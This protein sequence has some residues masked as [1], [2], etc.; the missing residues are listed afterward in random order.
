MG[1]YNFDEGWANNEWFFIYIEKGK[2]KCLGVEMR[3]CIQYPGS[4]TRSC[5]SFPTH[6]PSLPGKF[7]SNSMRK[8]PSSLPLLVLFLLI[9]KS[10]KLSKG[11]AKPAHMVPNRIV[12]Y[13][14]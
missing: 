3:E 14:C 9:E 8:V 11:C 2:L 1:P 12:W 5:T 6:L 4:M 7:P 10:K 13:L